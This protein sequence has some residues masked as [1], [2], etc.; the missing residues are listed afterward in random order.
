MPSDSAWPFI[1]SL[2]MEKVSDLIKKIKLCKNPRMHQLGLIESVCAQQSGFGQRGKL[3][4][5]VH[6]C[7]LV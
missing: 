1:L 3:A 6:K 4:L 5:S 7:K 2:L